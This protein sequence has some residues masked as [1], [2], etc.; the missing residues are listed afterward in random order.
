MQT[1]Q[2]WAII[3]GSLTKLVGL[4]NMVTKTKYGSRMMRFFPDNPV[5]DKTT[6]WL[7]HIIDVLQAS[8]VWAMSEE[9]MWFT[10]VK[11]LYGSRVAHRNHTH[12]NAGVYMILCEQQS[13]EKIY[14]GKSQNIPVRMESHAAAERGR[15]SLKRTA[16]AGHRHNN[17]SLDPNKGSCSLPVLLQGTPP[18]D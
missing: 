16:V 17:Y 7:S 10:Q 3:E 1:S 8:V 14:V 12:T 4:P 11:I 15:D 18:H 9:L 2:G 6:P 5:S 13:C